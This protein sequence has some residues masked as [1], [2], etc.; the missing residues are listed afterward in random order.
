MG[1]GKDWA[2]LTDGAKDPGGDTVDDGSSVDFT[3]KIVI[4]KGIAVAVADGGSDDNVFEGDDSSLGQGKDWAM[5]T[6][7]AKDPGANVGDDGSLVDNI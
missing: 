6:D 3:N 1:Q 5:L 4:E 2:M 7:G